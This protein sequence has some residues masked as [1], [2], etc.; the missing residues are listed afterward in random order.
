MPL[1]LLLLI[2]ELDHQPANPSQ[3]LEHTHFF[4]SPLLFH[5]FIHVDLDILVVQCLLSLVAQ[6]REAG[7]QRNHNDFP[8]YF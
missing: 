8:P 2:H 3:T 4:K 5:P 1:F 7:I 6:V